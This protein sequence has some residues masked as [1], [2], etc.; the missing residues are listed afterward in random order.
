MDNQ[1]NSEP[2]STRAKLGYW[3]VAWAGVA[4]V[5]LLINPSAIKAAPFFPAGL[6]G[7]FG[8]EENGI[9]AWMLGAWVLG[10]GLYIVL[11]ISMF[12]ETKRDAFF[13]TYLMLC[14]LL[15]LNVAGCQR[16]LSAVSGLH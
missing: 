5:T 1:P 10:W 2:I 4:L 6:L 3:F 15:A 9:I 7:L 11:T 12:R 14:V 16:T 13:R 8:N